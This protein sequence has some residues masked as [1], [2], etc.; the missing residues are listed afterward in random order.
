M[1][2]NDYSKE[3]YDKYCNSEDRILQVF[4]KDGFM[5]EGIFVGYFH[6]DIDAGE[7]YIHKW[8]FVPE[9]EIEKYHLVATA[10]MKNKFGRMIRQ[11]EIAR[12]QFKENK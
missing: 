8:H 6:G 7:H 3:I 5:L 12:V 2:E 11:E 4:L 9:S 10:E 1:K